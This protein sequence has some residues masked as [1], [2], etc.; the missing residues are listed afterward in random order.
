MAILERHPRADLL[1]YLDGA[2]EAGEKSALEKHL[3]SCAECC[4]RH[5]IGGVARRRNRCEFDVPGVGAHGYGWPECTTE[6][7]AGR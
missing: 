4:D 3:E 1:R 5:F 6:R 2:V 7:G